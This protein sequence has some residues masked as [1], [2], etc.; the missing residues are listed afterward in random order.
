[1]S[2]RT[3]PGLYGPSLLPRKTE[4]MWYTK[5]TKEA[6]M[7][8]LLRREEALRDKRD[9]IEWPRFRST[10]VSNVPERD[11]RGM[12]DDS[13][14]GS[15]MGEHSD[16]GGEILGETDESFDADDDLMS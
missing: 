12:D 1:M 3:Q 13:F 8:T 6:Q 16:M 15:S 5:Y 14:A 4:P 10:L 11:P 2:Y 7:E 9:T